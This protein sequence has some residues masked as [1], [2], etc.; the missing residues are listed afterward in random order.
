MKINYFD[1]I[2]YGNHGYNGTNKMIE[3]IEKMDK[4]TKYVI[5]MDEY[6]KKDKYNRQQINKEIMKYIIDNGDLIDE[7]NCFNIYKL[8]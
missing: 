1:L 2:N 3:R 4:D 7:I 8:K 6:N 5:S